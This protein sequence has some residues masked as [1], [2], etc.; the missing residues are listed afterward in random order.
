[1]SY[2]VVVVEE[3]GVQELMCCVYCRPDGRKKAFVKL[4][5]DVDALDVANK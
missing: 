4:T 1:M 3:R 5:K 2:G